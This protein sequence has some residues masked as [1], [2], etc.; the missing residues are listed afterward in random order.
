MVC[1]FVIL[2][3]WYQRNAGL[4]SCNVFCFPWKRLC[5]TDDV[6]FKCLI[7]FA[8][9]TIWAL[10]CYFIEVAVLRSRLCIEVSV[11][12]PSSSTAIFLRGHS[13]SYTTSVLIWIDGG[14]KHRQYLNKCKGYRRK[15]MCLGYFLGR[16]VTSLEKIQAFLLPVPHKREMLIS[17]YYTSGIII[18]S[19]SLIYI[20]YEVGVFLDIA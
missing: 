2:S 1:S 20:Y 12:V 9:E 18:F 11:I 15:L 19:P 17:E 6:F 7:E 14:F 5:K 4:I 8:I 13:K 3:F 10:N 16:L